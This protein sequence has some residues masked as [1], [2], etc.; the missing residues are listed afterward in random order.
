MNQA[1]YIKEAID[2]ALSQRYPRLDLIVMDGGST[3]RTVEI[4]KA[5]GDFIRWVSEKDKGQEALRERFQKMQRSAAQYSVSP[6][7]DRKRAMLAGYQAHVSKPVDTGELV[8]V[9]ASLAGRTGR[10]EEPSPAQ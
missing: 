8:A 2:S 5:Y 4:L 1:S 10:W 6:A 3:D 9:V 7:E